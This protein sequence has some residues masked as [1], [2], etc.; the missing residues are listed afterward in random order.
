MAFN[1]LFIS[2]I[3]NLQICVRLICRM[4]GVI[5]SVT[6]KDVPRLGRKALTSMGS[7]HTSH[8]EACQT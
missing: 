5:L 7:A 2:Q 1:I 6:C 4:E 8:L 3:D